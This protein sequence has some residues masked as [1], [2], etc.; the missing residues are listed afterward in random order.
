[1]FSLPAQICQCL[2]PHTLTITITVYGCI[3][4]RPLP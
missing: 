2:L 1:M 3:L 4:Q